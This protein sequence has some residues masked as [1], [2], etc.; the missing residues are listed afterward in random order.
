MGNFENIK[1]YSDFSHTAAGRGG[2]DKYLSELKSASYNHGRMDERGALAWEIPLAA[3]ASVGLW[4]LG[5][6][7]VRKIKNA[8][9]AKRALAENQ[10][11]Q[12][13]ASARECLESMD[14]TDI[15]EGNNENT[16]TE[17]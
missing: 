16:L 11:Q 14:E 8:Y 13:E 3:A 15:P 6:R 2:V 7:C 4:E 10:V 9:R 1:P 12:A 5:K 17:E